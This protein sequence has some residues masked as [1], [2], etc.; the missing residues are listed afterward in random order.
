[1]LLSLRALWG[2]QVFRVVS[3]GR[4][5]LGRAWDSQPAPGDSGASQ[6]DDPLSLG[7]SGS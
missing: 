5:A 3:A 1:M 4:K 2:A 7:L 6:D